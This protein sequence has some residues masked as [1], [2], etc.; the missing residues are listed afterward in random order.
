MQSDTFVKPTVRELDYKKL[1]LTN[2]NKNG[3]AENQKE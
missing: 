1:S 3:E 2:Y